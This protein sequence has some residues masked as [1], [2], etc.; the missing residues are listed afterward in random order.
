MYY[1][2]K[3][4]KKSI[5]SLPILVLSMGAAY[6]QTSK[7][8]PLQAYPS[9]EPDQE[10]KSGEM[11]RVGPPSSWRPTFRLPGTETDLRIGGYIKA[12]FIYDFDKDLGAVTNPFLADVTPRE[13]DGK[14]NAHALET[15]FNIGTS[16]PTKYGRLNTFFG[17]H[18]LGRPGRGEEELLSIRHAYAELGSL[19]AGRTWSNV[20]SFIASP[21][22]VKLGSP[23]GG[24]FTRPAQIRYSMKFTQDHQLSFSLE[25]HDAIISNASGNPTPRDDVSV[26]TNSSAP[27]LTARYEFG[28]RF[29][30]AGMVRELDV[31]SSGID[32]SAFSW[33]V[34]GHY[35]Q[36]LW[37][38]AVLKSA[39]W[40]GEGNGSYM[41]PSPTDGYVKDGKIKPI[42]HAS[43]YVALE[44][45]W[46]PRFTST[47]AYSR[48]QRSG[49]PDS[50]AAIERRRVDTIWA[51][52]FF[53]L[54]PRVNF[55]LGY[56]YA[57]SERFDGRNGNA[58]RI[59]AMMMTQF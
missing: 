16:T 3:V 25:D 50:L 30:L 8:P 48:V 28:R 47:L 53:N 29:A 22:I 42:E 19:L 57:R 38:S 31:E 44:Q 13:T 12:D 5:A 41:S 11:S 45:N 27:A 32:D 15:R 59:N 46:S 2:S 52:I 14:F 51:D 34:Y 7:G 37:S 10:L 20:M 39:L 1:F 49:V 58:N 24:V 54:T 6:A 23:T 40:V 43:G 36:P 26:A 9:M 18:M 33:G 56:A 17:S 4:I 21:R 35:A 55:G